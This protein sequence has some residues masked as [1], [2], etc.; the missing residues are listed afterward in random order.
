MKCR[1]T[2]YNVCYTKLLRPINRTPSG[3][4][5]ELTGESRESSSR[6]CWLSHK[7]GQLTRI[8]SKTRRSSLALNMPEHENANNQ[9]DTKI[10]VHRREFFAQLRFHAPALTAPARCSGRNIPPHRTPQKRADRQ[11]HSNCIK[12]RLPLRTRSGHTSTSPLF[13]ALRHVRQWC[14]GHPGNFLAAARSCLR[15]ARHRHAR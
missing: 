1:I 11:P 9:R 13:S 15:Q 14:I 12:L 5:F 3:I 8:L 7:P 6:F 10:A 2:S 4:L